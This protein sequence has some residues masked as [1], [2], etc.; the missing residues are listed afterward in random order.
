[1]YL[2]ILEFQFIKGIRKYNFIVCLI[3]RKIFLYSF[4]LDEFKIIRYPLTTESA[5][6]KI[7][8]TNTLV[9]I[10]DRRS[11][12]YSIK[13]AVQKLYD[14]KAARV[15]T[16]ILNDDGNKK[17]YVK[18]ASEFDALDVANKIGII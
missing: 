18:L 9:F 6:K 10:V 13:T 8:D 17:A 5:M 11:N 16:L 12:K 2:N 4:S 7:E 14:I 15:N 3:L 1:M